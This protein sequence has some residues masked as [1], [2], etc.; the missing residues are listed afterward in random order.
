MTLLCNLLVSSNIVCT[1]KEMIRLYP[2]VC[3]VRVNIQEIKPHQGDQSLFGL[4]G[5]CTR[6]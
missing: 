5:G 6:I 3:R 4:S 1:R 2:S